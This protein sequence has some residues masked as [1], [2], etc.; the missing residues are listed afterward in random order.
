MV[1]SVCRSKAG[2]NGVLKCSNVPNDS[3][4]LHLKQ[5]W[6][7][8]SRSNT[9]ELGTPCSRTIS[10]R[11]VRANW[12]KVQVFLMA[13]K[14]AVFM[15]LSTITQIVLF[16]RRVKGRPTMKSM[17]TKS[18]FQSGSSRVVRVLVVV[19]AL[20]SPVRKLSTLPCK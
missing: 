14:Y 5:D 19:D 16:F 12:S 20:S 7:L 1:R 18:H 9:R 17:D 8:A 11:Y 6:N 10:S 13:I 15:S 4:S 2:W 3:Y